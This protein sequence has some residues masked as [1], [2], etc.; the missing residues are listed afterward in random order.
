VRPESSGQEGALD[1]FAGRGKVRAGTKR[2]SVR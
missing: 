1:E 2:L